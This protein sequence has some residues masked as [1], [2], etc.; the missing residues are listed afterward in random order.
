MPDKAAIAD[1]YLRP[2][3]PYGSIYEVWER[4]LAAGDSITPS[5]YDDGY[6]QWMAALVAAATGVGR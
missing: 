5:S 3:A 6:C 2:R 4:G 1:F